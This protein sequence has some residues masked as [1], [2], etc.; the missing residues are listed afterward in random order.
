MKHTL[1]FFVLLTSQ[2][3]VYSQQD[4]LHLKSQQETNKEIARNFYQDLWFTNN[5][6]KYKDYVASEYVVHDIFERKGLTEPAIEQKNIADMF[7]ENGELQGKIDYQIAEGD[8]VAT[9]WHASL[10]PNTFFGKILGME[11]LAII[12]VFRIKDGKIVEIWNHRHDIETNQ[13][14]KFVFKG[15]LIGLLVALIP[16]IIAFRLRKKLRLIRNQ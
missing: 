12:N 6:E 7:W 15:L 11:K 3:D 16:T 5:T 13:T 9:R 1:L 14:L 8:F 10:K 2:L 4:S